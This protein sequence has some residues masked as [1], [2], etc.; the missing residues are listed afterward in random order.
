MVEIPTPKVR[1]AW[2]FD[3]PRSM[4]STIFR[5]RSL[6]YAFIR[7]CCHAAHP[8]RNTLL[9][10][11]TMGYNA[12]Q[13]KVTLWPPNPLKRGVTYK[14]VVSTQAKDLAG[15]RLDQNRNRAGLQPKVWYFTIEN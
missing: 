5:R 15:N 12:D 2:A 7:P 4:A 8:H 13:Q 14:P 3:M 10:D 9:E 6:E 11:A 1:A